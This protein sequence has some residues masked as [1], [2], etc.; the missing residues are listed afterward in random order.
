MDSKDIDKIMGAYKKEKEPRELNNRV[1]TSIKLQKQIE[2]YNKDHAL[3]FSL[4]VNEAGYNVLTLNFEPSDYPKTHDPLECEPM[5]NCE[6]Y[7]FIKG[8]YYLRDR[9]TI[10]GD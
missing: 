5:S 2:H 3:K 1:I 9:P 4:S 10:K 6:A 7:Y 8:F